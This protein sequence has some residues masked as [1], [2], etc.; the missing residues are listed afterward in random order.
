MAEPNDAFGGLL[1]AGRSGGRRGGAPIRISP[2]AGLACAQVQAWAGEQANLADALARIGVQL[3]D[4]QSFMETRGRLCGRIAPGRYLVLSET[5]VADV[6]AAV[7]GTVGAVADLSHA[8]AGLRLAGASVEALMAKA[9]AIDFRAA[10][11]PPG[12]LAQTAIHHM[13][14]LVLRRADDTFDLFVPTSFAVAFADWL[15]DAA[16]E[17]GWQA[18]A[19][20]GL[21]LAVDA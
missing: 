18:A 3:P 5:T 1:A 20:V 7:P 13:G 2:I 16:R 17:F 19:P 11:F 8:R 10:A 4:G 15:T 9:A 6:Q 14:C 12:H 21:R